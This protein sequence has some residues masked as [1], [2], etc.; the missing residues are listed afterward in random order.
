MRVFLVMNVMDMTAHE[1]IEVWATEA[2]AIARCRE[3]NNSEDRDPD[4]EQWE[5]DDREV[6]E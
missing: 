6:R 1:L 4:L 3:L 5:Y 2:A